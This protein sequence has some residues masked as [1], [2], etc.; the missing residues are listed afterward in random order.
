MTGPQKG[1]KLDFQKL[2]LT[3]SEYVFL[4]SLKTRKFRKT[5]FT[6]V[7]MCNSNFWTFS[8]IMSNCCRLGIMSFHK[9]Q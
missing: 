8:K 2:S 7:N 1:Q 6:V 4:F 3:K 5:T 9:I